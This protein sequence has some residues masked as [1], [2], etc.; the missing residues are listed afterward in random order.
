MLLCIAESC[1][2]QRSGKMEGLGVCN[3]GSGRVQ[4]CRG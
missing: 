2:E 4:V 3:E 1:S